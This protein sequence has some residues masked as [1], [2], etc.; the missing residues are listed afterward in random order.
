MS[1]S[2][3]SCPSCSADGSRAHGSFQPVGA[4][5]P[6]WT[7]WLG[8]QLLCAVALVW[9]LLLHSPSHFC[10]LPQMV[11]RHVELPDFQ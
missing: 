9:C 8:V 10:A 3:T 7:L 6:C 4:A 2:G 11:T 1:S 5:I